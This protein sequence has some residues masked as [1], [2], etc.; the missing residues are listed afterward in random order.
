MAKKKAFEVEFTI[1]PGTKFAS[2]GRK[3]F[4]QATNVKSVLSKFKK[5]PFSGSKITSIRRV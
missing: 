4:F 2:S 1:F 3:E 5:S